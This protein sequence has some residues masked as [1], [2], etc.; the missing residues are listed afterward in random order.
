MLL[1]Y[2]QWTKI[3]QEIDLDGQNATKTASSL[4]EHIEAYNLINIDSTT[5]IQYWKNQKNLKWKGIL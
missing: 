2:V 5:L 4:K 3:D 1:K